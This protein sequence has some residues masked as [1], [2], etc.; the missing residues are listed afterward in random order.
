MKQGVKKKKRKVDDFLLGV[1]GNGDKTMKE[2]KEEN[3]D[4]TSKAFKH[5]QIRE[6]K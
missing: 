4:F 2:Y 1:S 6:D 5:F 3:L